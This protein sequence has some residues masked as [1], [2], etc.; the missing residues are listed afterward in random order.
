MSGM[1]LLI[2][3]SYVISCGDQYA[4][5][6]GLHLMLLFK[7]W[8]PRRNKDSLSMF[9]RY[10]LLSTS[11]ELVPRYSPRISIRFFW[12]YQQSLSTVC[13]FLQLNPGIICLRNIFP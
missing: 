8:A 13:F 4:G 12:N 10:C 2:G 11:Y 6:L 7:A 1:V 9:C 5:L 3:T